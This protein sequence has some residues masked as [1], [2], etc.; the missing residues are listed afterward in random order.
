M[1]ATV[2]LT[3]EH[4]EVTQKA[5]AAF[6]AEAKAAPGNLRAILMA[7][8]VERRL[9][10]ALAVLEARERGL[11]EFLTRVRASLKRAAKGT[12]VPQRTL[13]GLVMAASRIGPLAFGHADWHR[14]MARLGGAEPAAASAA[15]K[16][17]KER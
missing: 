7:S 8:E 3:K 17:G 9:V 6:K 13:S 11:D 4:V 5:L 12:R 14:L 16:G 10:S 2:E 1:N 15:K